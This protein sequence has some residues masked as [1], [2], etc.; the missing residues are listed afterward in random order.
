MIS[1]NTEN[2]KCSEKSLVPEV[3]RPEQIYHIVTLGKSFTSLPLV[4]VFL[5]GKN[6]VIYL[7]YSPVLP[8]EPGGNL[9]DRS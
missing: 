8:S 9:Q 5:S 7:I 2:I 4:T 3:R 6:S 1:N